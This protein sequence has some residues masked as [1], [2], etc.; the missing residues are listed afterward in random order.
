MSVFVYAGVGKGP[1]ALKK[2]TTA[3]SQRASPS[4]CWP[5]PETPGL[6]PSQRSRVQAGITGG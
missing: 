1:P 4:G 3:P 2:A 6:K 5:Q